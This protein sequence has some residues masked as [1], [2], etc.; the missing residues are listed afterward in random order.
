MKLTRILKINEKEFYDFLENDL[1][2]NIYQSSGKEL[3]VEDIKKGLR[4]SKYD[5]NAHTRIDITILEY[6][7]G[8][9]YKA[10]IKSLMDTITISYE[11]EVVDEGLRII[12]NQN[13]ESF[14]KEKHNKIMR[15]FSEA[16]YYGRMTD[17][18]YDIEKKITNLREGIVEP[19]KPKPLEHQQLTNLFSKKSDRV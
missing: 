1:L 17:T 10:Q 9:F 6:K 19:V 11:T 8:E 3:S 5:N 14:E 16:V 18:L 2:S 13:I 12:F 7:R 4:Y 15:M